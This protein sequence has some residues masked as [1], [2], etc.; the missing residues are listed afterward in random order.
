MVDCSFANEILREPLY[1][2]S[3]EERK[4]RLLEMLRTVCAHHMEH[5]VPYRRLC[6]K[7]K[8]RPEN[9]DTLEDIPYLPSSLFKDTLLL[10]IPE[11]QVFRELRSSATTSGRPSRIGLDKENNRRWT[12]SM[13]RM[14]MERIGDERLRLMVLD[15]PGVLG[16]SEVV[17]ARASMT[18]SLLFMAREVETCIKN[19]NE[20]P[21]LDIDT[22]ASFLEHTRR[23]EGTMLFGFTFILSLYA[24]KPLLASG[25]TFDLPDLKVLHAGGWKKLQELSV[26][27]EQLVEDCVQC[28]GVAP[29]NVI[30]LYGFSEQGGLL[31][32]TCE[33]GRRH[34]PAWSEVIVRD[35]LTLEPLPPGERGL[36]QF[37]TPIQLSY[38]GHSII[39]EDTGMIHGVDDCPCGRKG[40]TFSILGRSEQAT[41]ERGCGDIMA[42]LFA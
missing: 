8:V 12:I 7:R 17:P 22:L 29:E 13:Q 41:E 30:D 39:T 6:E 23:G 15:E 40:T 24:V 42:E 20:R 34:T 16:R 1:A 28:F 2:I 19:E 10:S 14:L 36:M 35:P 31:Y 38:P 21:S 37:L 4:K 27:P 3:S 11:E 9:I 18:R 33:F 32:P 26:G 25:R 5:C